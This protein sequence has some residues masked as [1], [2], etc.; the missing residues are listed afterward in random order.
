MP[1]VLIASSLQLQCYICCQ[2]HARDKRVDP[3]LNWNEVARAMSGFTGADCMG[4]MLRAQGMAARQVSK[5]GESVGIHTWL[6]TLGVRDSRVSVWDV[7]R[8]IQRLGAVWDH[9]PR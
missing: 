1:L 8:V 9:R 2:V 6:Q 3:N 4:L 5:C 7:N